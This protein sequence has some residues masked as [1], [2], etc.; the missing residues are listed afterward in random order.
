M[1][2]ILRRVVSSLQTNDDAIIVERGEINLG[3]R[4]MAWWQGRDL[5]TQTGAG[6][7][8]A[9]RRSGKTKRAR[10]KAKGPRV[11][12]PTNDL[13]RNAPSVQKAKAQAGAGEETAESSKKKENP[14]GLATRKSDKMIRNSASPIRDMDMAD[15]LEVMWDAPV[16]TPGGI[17]G[18]VDLLEPVIQ[19]LKPFKEVLDICAGDGQVMDYLREHHQA[20]TVAYDTSE[21]LCD[22][23]RGEVRNYAPRRANFGAERFDFVCALEGM[24]DEEDREEILKAA[25]D[26]MKVG[27]KMLLVDAIGDAPNGKVPYLARHDG[28]EAPVLSAR[29]YKKILADCGLKL[30]GTENITQIYQHRLKMGWAKA[31]ELFRTRRMDERSRDI[32]K[33][34]S[35]HQFDRLKSLHERHAKIMRL[36]LTK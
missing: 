35:V 26:A 7:S 31:A 16:R 10:P 9:S 24:Q 17:K 14:A 30:I 19:N 21:L 5:V 33:E 8:S 13:S 29:Y 36:E 3:K 18:A 1:K 4:L 2:Q 15:L 27:G 12:K 6:R 32:L 23:S 20:V 34:Q 22:Q 11:G 25:T 28:F